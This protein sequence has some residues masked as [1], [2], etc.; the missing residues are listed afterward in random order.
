MFIY[1]IVVLPSE[2]SAIKRSKTDNGNKEKKRKSSPSRERKKSETE[3]TIEIDG[4]VETHVHLSPRIPAND[5]PEP[6]ELIKALQ[7]LES[8]L[9]ST[10]E[11]VRQ[12]VAQL[13]RDVSEVSALAEIEGI[14][15]ASLIN[16]NY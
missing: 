1:L 14:L 16:Y 10:D 5:P 13:P 12:R 3:V 15:Q 6:E 7:E 8:N 11:V 2:K 4:T 9:A